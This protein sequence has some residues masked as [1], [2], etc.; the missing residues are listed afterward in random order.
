[1]PDIPPIHPLYSV[2]EKN[3]ITAQV[4]GVWWNGKVDVRTRSGK[5]MTLSLAQQ[6]RWSNTGMNNPVKP[7]FYAVSTYEIQKI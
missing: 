2:I 7:K 4:F 3:G 6:R 1:M 5:E